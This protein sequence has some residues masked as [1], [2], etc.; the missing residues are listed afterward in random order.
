MPNNGSLQKN[1]STSAAVTMPFL[2]KTFENKAI[3]NV[4]NSNQVKADLSN[5]RDREKNSFHA[6]SRKED[7]PKS[8]DHLTKLLSKHKVNDTNLIGNGEPPVSHIITP[9]GTADGYSIGIDYDN[10][11]TEIPGFW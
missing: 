10:L 9:R 6:N 1:H 4:V 8:V 7:Y 11:I 2:N 5:D 3:H